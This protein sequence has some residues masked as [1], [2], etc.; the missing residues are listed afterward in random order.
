MCDEDWEIRAAAMRVTRST[1]P[2][3]NNKTK[4]F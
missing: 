3:R 4:L 2:V 1:L